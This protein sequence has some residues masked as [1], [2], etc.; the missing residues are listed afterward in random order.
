VGSEID[1]DYRKSIEKYGQERRSL[2][3]SQDKDI[4]MD[5]YRNSNE[6]LDNILP[7]FSSKYPQI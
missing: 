2:V 4:P 6:K 7:E 3:K 5:V 1:S